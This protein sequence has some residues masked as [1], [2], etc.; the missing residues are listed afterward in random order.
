[1]DTFKVV[2]VVAIT[3]S[4]ASIGFIGAVAYDAIQYSKTPD[5]QYGMVASKSPVTDNPVAN[6]MVSLY[7]GKTLY[8]QNNA[9]L[10]DSLQV[11]QSYL[12]DCRIDFNNKITLIDKASQP[13]RGTM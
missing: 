6:Y 8:I 10:Y 13:D 1:M 11:N 12:F 2:V 7:S 9:T 3:L 5:Q 4:L